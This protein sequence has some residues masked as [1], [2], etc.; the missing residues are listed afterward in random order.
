MPMA[1]ISTTKGLAVTS[2][3]N[4]LPV[5]VATNG[6]GVG[7]VPVASGGLPVF[8]TS[9]TLFGPP[10]IPAN[11][12]LPVI[13]GLTQV[14][15]TLFTTVGTW[16]GTAATYTFQWK[17]GGANI[18]GATASS[19]LLVTADLAAN[20]T[21]TVTATNTAGSASATATAVGPVT[22]A[23]PVN[24]V[25][26]TITGGTVQG[27]VLT[28]TTGTWS[29]SPTYAYQWKRSGTNVGT[30]ANTYTTVA[31]DVGSTITV[32]VTAT[33]AGGNANATSAAVGPITAAVVG[34]IATPS[35]TSLTTATDSGASSTDAITNDTT[36]DLN[37]DWG[38]DPPLLDDVIEVRNG[39]SLIVTHTVTLAEE[40]SGI[41]SLGF[42][43]SAGSNSLTVTHKRGASSSS[44]S[45]AF[46]V[47]IDTTAP[48]LLSATAVKTGITTATLGVTTNETGGT[49]YGVLTL[50]STLPTA[51]QI[52]AGQN[53][54]GSA[55]AY[56]FNQA[57]SATGN[58]PKSATGLTGSTTYFAYY[59]HEDVAGN[60]S[61]VPTGVSFTTDAGAFSVLALPGLIGWY[62][63][64][65][66]SSMKTT[67][68]GTATNGQVVETWQDQSG[69]GNHLV[70]NVSA[71]AP[72]LNTTGF[73]TSFPTL[74]FDGTSNSLEKT[75]YA[76]GTGNKLTVFAVTRMDTGG[77]NYHR[78][79]SYVKV[80][81]SDGFS[82]PGS[83]SILLKSVANAEII[84]AATG[85][86]STPGAL[87]FD[88]PAIVAAIYT[89]SVISVYVNNVR[90]GTGN[91]MTSPFATGGKLKLCGED[92]ATNWLGRVS[93]VII[94]NADNTAEATN[95]YNYLK[96]KWGL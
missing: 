48:T 9:G 1:V 96:T 19:Y 7:V 50:N 10:V 84:T 54:A 55:A 82:N 64:S 85:V 63:A 5:V 46:I 95:A 4:G 67:G 27:D 11:T 32:T 30:N 39:G 31:G 15:Q 42:T 65:V 81:D 20:I 91:A 24:S 25:L 45:S 3:P 86:L 6:Y 16:S 23:A 2:A 47:V 49:L 93:E 52:K 13:S 76:I 21:V 17:R 34:A 73:N 70:K 14:G 22:V 60:Q 94:C 33:N 71:T 59:M 72:T 8:D 28:A 83:S 75:G 58:Q 43:L 74:V 12:G 56:A 38:A 53:A 62:D 40:M 57:V 44:P 80:G 26:P 29:G 41:V 36:P 92:G 79:L 69:V 89:G 77:D 88:T 66:A 18:S 68:G 90:A 87:A 61:T 78:L 37:V 51:A 35:V